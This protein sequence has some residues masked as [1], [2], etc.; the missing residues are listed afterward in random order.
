MNDLPPIEPTH[1]PAHDPA[2]EEA[3]TTWDAQ[4]H[5]WLMG[6]AAIIAGVMLLLELRSGFAWATIFFSVIALLGGAW[7]LWMATTS[8]EL[9]DEGIH[10][11]R[12]VGSQSITWQQMIS[13]TAQG[14]FFTVLTVLYH[15][16]RADGLVD[17]DAVASL[18]T[19]AVKNQGELLDQLEKRV[20]R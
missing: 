10:L 17:T 6:G 2:P 4:G 7:S 19:P 18:L 8:I 16:R 12:L 5:Y 3:Q 9:S 14:R 1:D 20:T 13:V 11:K 15:P